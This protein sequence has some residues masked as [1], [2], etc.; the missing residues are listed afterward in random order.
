MTQKKS[1]KPTKKVEKKKATKAVKTEKYATFKQ[2]ERLTKQVATLTTKLKQA[3]QKASKK[4]TP[5]KLSP[6]NKF[7]KAGLK[8]GKNF[9]EI[10]SEW[11]NKNSGKK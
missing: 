6:Y 1:K 4:S 2:V 7:V 5:R 8:K 10:S 9:K 3:G 11:K